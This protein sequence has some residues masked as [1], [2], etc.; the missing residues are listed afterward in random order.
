[1]EESPEYRRAVEAAMDFAAPKARSQAEVRDH[2]SGMGFSEDTVEA[3]ASRV[4]EL[5]VTNDRMLAEDLVRHLTGKSL[6]RT[7]IFRRLQ[8]RGLDPGLADGF[9]DDTE[10]GSSEYQRALAAARR[11]SR[12]LEDLEPEPAFRRL[13]GHLARRGFDEETVLTVSREV[14]GRDVTEGGD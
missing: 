5:G 7:E 8:N 4:D 6:G 14:L 13:T 10:D 9:L 2:L 1:M 11:K 3:A 12:S